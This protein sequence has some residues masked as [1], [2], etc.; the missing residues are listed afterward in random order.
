MPKFSIIVPVYNVER[1]YLEAA[2][3]SMHSQTF[4]DWECICV[5]DGSTNDSG[6]VLNDFAA[7]DPRFKVHHR[8]NQGVS[9]ARNFA[10]S[11]A[12]GEWIM[13]LDGDDL[14][15]PLTL[16]E[17]SRLS[18]KYP[19]SKIIRFWH[20]DFVDTFVGC[21]NQENRFL[22]GVYDLSA[23][24]PESFAYLT[25][26]EFAFHKSMIRNHTF[27]NY[28]IGEDTVFALTC[29]KYASCYTYSTRKFYGY[30]QRITSVCHA[31]TPKCQ[32]DHLRSMVDRLKLFKDDPRKNHIYEFPFIT[33]FLAHDYII[34]TSRISDSSTRKELWNEW[35]DSLSFLSTRNEFL[36][37]YH[38]LFAICTVLKFRF[39]AYCLGGIALA[40][41]WRIQ[42]PFAKL[43]DPKSSEE[44]ATKFIALDGVSVPG[45]QA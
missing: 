9:A 2:L 13:F 34:N 35:F 33:R 37:P 7:K 40:L 17:I 27:G 11:Q 12:C 26:W 8:T 31:I 1:E 18:L 39:V 24:I 19:E 30:R 14:Y 36:K 45:I 28:R 42:L 43:L 38:Y 23:C 3:N 21:S 16:S 4:T 22:E 15:D 6:K 25:I 20:E 41:A 32:L 44:A 10:L 5:D 29:L